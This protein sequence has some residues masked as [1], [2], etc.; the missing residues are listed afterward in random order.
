MNGAWRVP[1][2]FRPSND[3]GARRK[4]KTKLRFRFGFNFAG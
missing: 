2:A 4:K 1:L 3:V